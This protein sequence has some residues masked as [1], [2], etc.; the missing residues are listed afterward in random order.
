MVFKT[1][2]EACFTTNYDPQLEG[3]DLYPKFLGLLHTPHQPNF[4]R[5]PKS[6]NFS[7]VNDAPTPGVGP[8]GGQKKFSDHCVCS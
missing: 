5:W 2:E 6:G 1:M 4:V 7:R 8:H 3:G